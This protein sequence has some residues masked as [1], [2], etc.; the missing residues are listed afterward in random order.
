ME[1][2]MWKNEKNTFDKIADEARK[3]GKVID[4]S[5]GY[6]SKSGNLRDN[7]RDS[8]RAMVYE[9]KNPNGEQ[10]LFMEN[11]SVAEF[12]Y[13]YD[14]K[15]NNQVSIV[16]D[17][18][19]KEFAYYLH[20]GP[21]GHNLLALVSTE[22]SEIPLY[23]DKMDHQASLLKYREIGKLSDS[24]KGSTIRETIEKTLLDHP[25]LKNEAYEI[26]TGF[27]QILSVDRD[28]NIEPLTPIEIENAMLKDRIRELEVARRKTE[29]SQTE[30]IASLTEEVSS[31][32]EENEKLNEE[33]RNLK[34]ENGKQKTQ[35]EKLQSMLG[36]TLD[37]AGKVRDSVVGKFFFKKQL[38][39]LD[40]NEKALPVPEER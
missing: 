27:D 17:K 25:Y 23:D 6:M 35:I 3:S 14:K 22:K 18:R 29:K 19:T 5:Y 37:F 36:K 16:Y 20:S 24:E 31:L 15:G 1:I 12:N 34:E 30:K 40:K 39:E 26:L 9:F 32:Q 2:T 4:L 8:Q 7:Q 21:N 33:N 28:R 13:E 11:D 10:I 38:Q